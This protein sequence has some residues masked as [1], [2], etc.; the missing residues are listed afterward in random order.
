[1]MIQ[2]GMR[3]KI[4]VVNSTAIEGLV[5]EEQHNVMH[6]VRSLLDHY[7]VDHIKSHNIL[8][9]NMT[10]FLTGAFSFHVSQLI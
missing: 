3:K 6:Y 5:M 10:E 8:S 2:K 9:L 7:P 4:I 1:M